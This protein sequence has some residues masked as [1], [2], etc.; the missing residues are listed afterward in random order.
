MNWSP[1]K[2][3]ELKKLPET[4]K[5]TFGKAVENGEA[6]VIVN[7]QIKVNGETLTGAMST[8]N[9]V[10]T[11]STADFGEPVDNAYNVEIPA[12]NLKIADQESIAFT[13]NYT[14]KVIEG[15]ATTVAAQTQTKN[16]A[17]VSSIVIKFTMNG[18][19]TVPVGN[20][21]IDPD[22]KPYLTCNGKNYYGELSWVNNSGYYVQSDC[23]LTFAPAITE[24]GD[25][26]LVIPAGAIMNNGS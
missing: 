22:Y 20:R 9:G 1:E 16:L 2:D 19:T 21:G 5:I 26:T 12:G 8:S 13:S 11:I 24:P 23:N 14:L 3:S 17:E 4:I 6:V 10:I 18:S 15:V 25:Y 7:N